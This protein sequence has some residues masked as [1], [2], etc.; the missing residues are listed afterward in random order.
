MIKFSGCKKNKPDY[1]F[2][3]RDEA[4]NKKCRETTKL[5]RDK[6]KERISEYNKLAVMKNNNGTN[7]IHERFHRS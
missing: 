3:N 6:N 5:Q 2:K 7:R 1:D 4:K